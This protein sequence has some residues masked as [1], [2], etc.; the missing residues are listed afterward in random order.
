MKENLDY[1]IWLLITGILVIVLMPI[2]L[3]SNSFCESL[4]FTNTGQIGDT[5]GGITA[6]FLS[7]IGSFLVYFALR[8][9]VKANE[10]IQTQIDDT[11]K[12]KTNES[13]GEN[14]NQLYLYLTESI[15][16]FRFKFL[17]IG[18]VDNTND[19]ETGIEYKG[20]EAI[21]Y[22]FSNIFCDYHG[23]DE[24]LNCNPSVSELLSTL[25]IMDILLDKLEKAESKNKEI[26]MIL[27]R[28]QFNYK[29]ETR[30]KEEDEDGL[31]RKQ[32][33]ICNFEHGIPKEL[34]DLIISIRKKL[35]HNLR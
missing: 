18:H 15:D 31:N 6:P 21:Y 22:L 5:I 19:K 33:S 12:E 34:K 24:D 16:N 2:L 17:S 13:E 14:L 27:V 11:K 28:H 35:T 1:A 32:C 7:L 26:L 4:N 3:T 30:I 9:Q 25:K 10:L 29:I 23:S 8:A 20:S